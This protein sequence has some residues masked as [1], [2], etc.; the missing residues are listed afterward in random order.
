[1]LS[2]SRQHAVPLQILSNIA[3]IST[4][5]YLL[6]SGIQR[7]ISH[8]FFLGVAVILITGLLRYIDLIGDYIGAALL[9]MLF[10]AILLGAANYW[11]K[12]PQEAAP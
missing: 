7:G 3:L 8:Y 9:F 10:A 12:R 11:K 1:M 2:D 5:V 6:I 4:G